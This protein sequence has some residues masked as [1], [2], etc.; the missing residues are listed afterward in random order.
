[1]SECIELRNG[2][3]EGLEHDISAH[4]IECVSKIQFYT[5]RFMGSGASIP[6]AELS[7]PLF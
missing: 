2:V 4:G 5:D 3:I 7:L 1:M 6:Q